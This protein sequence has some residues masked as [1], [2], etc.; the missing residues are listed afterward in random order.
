MFFFQY[1]P[2]LDDKAVIRFLAATI[3]FLVA[4]SRWLV[5]IIG[6]LALVIGFGRAKGLGPWAQLDL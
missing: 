5:A 6:F 4:V 1:H 2:L 3:G